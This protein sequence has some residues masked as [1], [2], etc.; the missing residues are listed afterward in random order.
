MM[1][2]R[3]GRCACGFVDGLWLEGLSTRLREMQAVGKFSIGGYLPDRFGGR[4]VVAVVLLALA[5]LNGVGYGVL[6]VFS[7]TP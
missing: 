4:R 2:A 7:S 6:C 1:A 3:R 5:L